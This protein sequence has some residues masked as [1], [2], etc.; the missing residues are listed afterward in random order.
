[1]RISS[2]KPAP[3]LALNLHHLLSDGA[4]VNTQSRSSLTSYADITFIIADES[5]SIM[6]VISRSLT[7]APSESRW[8]R[9]TAITEPALLTRCTSEL[10]SIN[11]TALIHNTAFSTE[12]VIWSES[13]E[14]YAQSKH[15]LQAKT[16]LNK[17]VGEF[18]C[19]RT[20]S[21]GLSHWR[22]SYYGL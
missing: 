10:H 3:W 18:L 2:V 11:C 5:H 13:G 9:F 17:Y 21:D 1:M 6:N 12:K 20:T 22:K 16:D 15:F 7:A 19:E 8:W 4:A 14:K